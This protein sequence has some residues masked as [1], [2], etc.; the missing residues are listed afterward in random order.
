MWSASAVVN[1]SDF[2]ITKVLD[3]QSGL[4]S[5]RYRCE[6]GSLWLTED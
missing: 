1:I 2:S 4:S 6:L 5:T 3:R